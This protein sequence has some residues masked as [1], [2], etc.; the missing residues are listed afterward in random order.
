MVP[1]ARL[2]VAIIL[3]G[4]ALVPSMAP[5]DARPLLAESRPAVT[6]GHRAFLGP[7][8]ALTT[9]HETPGHGVWPLDP[10]P[11]V[12]ARFDPPSSPFGPG[13][14]GVDLLGRPGQ[15]VRAALAGR[16]SFA[17]VIAGRGVVVVDHGSTRTTY[18]PVRAVVHLGDE[19]TAGEVLGRVETGGSHCFPRTC[20]HW[21]LIEGA[22]HYLDPLTLVGA[23]PVRLLPLLR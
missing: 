9:P 6:V 15:P 11:D 23:G 16:I 14:R 18:E 3:L 12:V 17:G 20:L 5:A 2:F 22:E 7:P 19:V 13:H 4:V 21:G 1:V 8:A 10:R